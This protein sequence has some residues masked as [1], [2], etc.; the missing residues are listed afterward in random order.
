MKRRLKCAQEIH[1]RADQAMLK[2]AGAGTKLSD[3]CRKY[4]RSDAIYY[5]SKAKYALKDHWYMEGQSLVEW[6]RF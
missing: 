1:R 2:E 6:Q 3:L 5:N 4:G